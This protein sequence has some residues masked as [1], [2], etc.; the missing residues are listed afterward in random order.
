MYYIIINRR[1]FQGYPYVIRYRE[2]L[3]EN[4]EIAAD[5]ERRMGIFK[6]HILSFG[7]EGL[8]G[9]VACIN[10]YY[11]DQQRQKKKMRE[12][13]NE[14]KN[15]VKHNAALKQ[16]L[17]IMF[18][19]QFNNPRL[20]TMRVFKSWKNYVES[21]KLSRSSYNYEAVLRFKN[22]TEDNIV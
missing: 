9:N 3:S 15:I 20:L 7:D 22:E 2:L 11:L 21:K 17:Q 12:I 18:S 4:Y 19:R 6:K 13:F 10:Y 14:W 1:Y 8:K 16:N 5:N